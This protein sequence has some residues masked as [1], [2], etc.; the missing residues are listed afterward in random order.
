[1][2][3][4]RP[5]VQRHTEA[6]AQRYDGKTVIFS[7]SR[8]DYTKGIIHQLQAVDALLAAN[9]DRRDLVYKVVVSPSREDLAEYQDEKLASAAL[10]EAINSSYGDETWQPVEYEYRNYDFDEMV[11]WYRRADIMLVAPLIDGMNLIAKEYIATHDDSGMLVLSKR[12]GA[13]AQLH[14]AVLVDP[15]DIAGTARELE[16]ALAM[17]PVER[18][19]R[20]QALRDNVQTEDVHAWARQFMHDLDPLHL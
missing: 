9:P 3:A 19:R 17:A 2:A 6:L 15:R 5:E 1:M 4:Q 14:Q 11:A 12:A 13:A 20:M 7:V 10:A 8:L 16:A 18:A